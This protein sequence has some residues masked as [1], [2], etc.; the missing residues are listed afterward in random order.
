M[1]GSSP[2]DDL[3]GMYAA[4]ESFVVPYTMLDR[5]VINSL[6]ARNKNYNEHPFIARAAIGAEH[7]KQDKKFNWRLTNLLEEAETAME[8]F[9]V[10]KFI[11]VRE[12]VVQ[13]TIARMADTA[14]DIYSKDR[15]QPSSRTVAELGAA[16][17][18]RGV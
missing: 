5:A 7:S 12:I 16:L 10:E 11:A 9:D 4:L 8:N 3:P 2:V 18:A 17:V 13:T 6:S 1:E 15:N 14:L